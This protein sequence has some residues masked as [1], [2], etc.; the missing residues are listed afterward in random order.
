MSTKQKRENELWE[1]QNTSIKFFFLHIT[2]EEM[3]KI[4]ALKKD[5][6]CQSD[7]FLPS[8][9]ATQRKAKEQKWKSEDFQI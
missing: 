3:I 9:T 4:N 8:L 7:P 5:T 1:K 6:S 2:K